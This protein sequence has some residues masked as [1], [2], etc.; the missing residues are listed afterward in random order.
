MSDMREIEE[1][2]RKLREEIEYH[3]YRYYVLD[4]PV[5]SDVEYDRLMQELIDLEEAYP[6][7]VTADSPTQRVGSEP[8]TAFE[9]IIHSSPMM[10]LTNSYSLEELKAFD[11]RVRKA[12]PGE[13][14]EYV[15]ELKVDGLAVSLTYEDGYFARGA[16]RGDGT[17]GEDV[18][19][20]LKT[21]RSV[22]M[23]IRYQN[24][25]TVDVRGEVFMPR[26]EF[27]KLNEERRLKGEALFANPRN[28][29]AG[30]LRQL[31]PRITASRQLD[32]FV[33][34]VG[35]VSGVTLGTQMEVLDFLRECGFRVNPNVKLCRSID[36]VMD[37]AETWNDKREDIDYEIDGIVVKVNSLDQQARLGSTARSPRW[38]T[39]Y[40]F[41]AKQGTTVVKDII[42]QVGRT[43]TL[44]P[45]AL[46]EPIEL[47]GSVVSRASLH[48]EDIIRSKD[49][50]I[51]DAVVIEKGG[52]IIPEVVKVIPERRTGNER[53]FTM[54]TKCP[55]CGSD[56][57]R[58]EGEVASRCT[59]ETCP[60]QIREGIIFFASRDAMDIEGMGPQ[61]VSQLL[62]SGLV[63][64]V[65]DIYSLKFEDLVNLERMGEKSA[66]NL[67]NA[68]EA[69]KSRPLHR[70]INAL[71]IRLVGERT[72]RDLASHFGSMDKL[73]K[74]TYD[75][76]ISIPEVGPKVAESIVAFFGN[77]RNL[78]AIGN[79]QAK[80]VN[81]VE[82]RA[83]ASAQ[84]TNVFTGKTVVFTGS[85][86]RF[87]RKEAE[88]RVLESGG[89]TSGSVGKKT[90]YVVVGKDPG[91]KYDKAKALG[92]TILTEEE[93]ERM[94]KGDEI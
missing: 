35:N 60:A 56:V 90:D 83:D 12:L 53:E 4:D 36:E 40:K 62:K 88:A 94:L 8:I 50:R 11:S 31:D 75:E 69:S 43:G 77:P 21:I 26:R 18:T 55:E 34:G 70:L 38:A 30:S 82:P 3:N 76:L 45:V 54:P 22:P 78:E 84:R 5:I 46:L 92:I 65:D 28:A 15:A 72:A 44:T 29:A 81:M 79:L 89:K 57:V 61:I 39:A 17:R 7:L 14:V 71:G 73:S 19:H 1:R 58:P 67:L 64:G 49:I 16:T 59:N 47:A 10:S 27:R 25:V 20:N 42:V 91:S 37:Y 32:I 74:A 51:G 52:D 9:Q 93:F 68:I 13:G 66:E 33:Y 24:P 86:E 2:L 80:G 23:R 41:P 6:E 85:L 87:T 63:S 48:N